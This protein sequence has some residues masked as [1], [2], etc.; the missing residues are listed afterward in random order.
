VHKK[1]GKS[2]IFF[3]GGGGLEE[4]VIFSPHE[5]LRLG[6][7]FL[8]LKPQNIYTPVSIDLLQSKMKKKII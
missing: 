3:L 4:I 8:M 1:S 2:S 7:T 6:Y 5:W